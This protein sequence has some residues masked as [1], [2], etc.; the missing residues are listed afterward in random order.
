MLTKH[1]LA[2]FWLGGWEREDVGATGLG[3]I[4]EA[5]P[6]YGGD[7]VHGEL[8]RRSLANMKPGQALNPVRLGWAL[9]PRHRA[10]DR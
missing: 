1:F 2:A 4:F 5:D 7:D 9:S 6:E 3:F 10:R 8:H